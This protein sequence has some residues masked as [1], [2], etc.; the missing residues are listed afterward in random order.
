MEPADK[1]ICRVDIYIFQRKWHLF[2]LCFSLQLHV[3]H[4]VK[5]ED[6]SIIPQIPQNVTVR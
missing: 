6:A 4:L 5:M 1:S 3:T 2:G